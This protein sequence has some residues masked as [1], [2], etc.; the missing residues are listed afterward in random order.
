MM[1]GSGWGYP[2]LTC[3]AILL[4]LLIS[5]CAPTHGQA[6]DSI[7]A[8][9][10]SSVRGAQGAL[11]RQ[12]QD[13]TVTT[14]DFNEFNRGDYIGTQYEV[15]YGV[16]LSASGGLGFEPRIF[17]SNDIGTADYG[18][19]DLGSPNQRCP[20]GGPGV[21]EGG[22][23][24]QDGENC[25]AL[26]N[27]LIIQ[28]DNGV[29]SGI[30]DDNGG[31]GEIV[32][33]FTTQA[34]YVYEMG[35]LDTD[36]GGKITIEHE[37]GATTKILATW[38]DNAKEIKAIDIAKVNKITV[39][40]EKSGAV[41][42][43]SFCPGTDTEPS[44]TTPPPTTP[45]PTTP[46]PTTPSPTPLPGSPTSYTTTHVFSIDDVM[47]GFD[48]STFGP[49]GAMQDTTILCGLPSSTSPGTCPSSMTDKDGTVLYPIDSE[50]GFNVLDFVGAQ[51][52][53]RDFNHLEGF[54]GNVAGGGL[55][56]SNVGTS[57]YKTKPPLGTWCQGLSATS[58]KCSTEHYSV[59]EHVLSCHE[60]CPYQLA[61]PI[62]GEQ[63]VQS[64]PDGS[65]TFDCANAELDNDVKEITDGVVGDSY[66][67]PPFL[68]PNDNT[69]VLNEIA[70]SRDYSI[71]LKDDGK[72][73]YRW[74]SLI[75]LPTDVRLYAKLELPDEWKQTGADFTVKS[76]KLVVRHQI[77]NNPNDQ[78][79]PED[80]EN[81]AATGR[82]PS[83]A[84]S[85]SDGTDIWSSRVPCY[86]GD[87]DFIE[88]DDGSS[89][90]DFLPAGT[91]FKG[92]FKGDNLAALNPPQ[93]FSEDLVEG[94]TNGWYTTINRDPFEWS[95]RDTTQPDNIFDF[96]GFNEPLNDLEMATQNLELVSGPRWRLKA[97]KFGQDIPGTSGKTCLWST[98]VFLYANIF[99]SRT[100]QAST[101]LKKNAANHRSRWT[102]S[103]IA[104]GMKLS[105]P[106]T[107]SIGT[108]KR[109]GRLLWLRAR[110]GSTSPRT[111]SS[112]LTRS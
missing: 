49:S 56:I 39:E 19:P 34:E 27:L 53:S 91:V 7:Q 9:S 69:D 12:L 80:L 90:P 4:L 3:S 65:A 55:K 104:L 84:V 46:P 106:S 95:Y 110:A 43:I 61:D 92:K 86:E 35:F 63:A 15:Q 78:I 41:I 22:E 2:I 31:G 88:G 71:T 18:D 103:S 102:T 96:V 29:N 42:F 109:T 85:D 57:T 14:L 36:Y 5:A 50:F 1:H 45:P 20:Q 66:I 10:R 89:D 32:F 24:G 48:G 67:P 6:T 52:I 97:G 82:K 76:A 59:M 17:D 68:E 93:L 107:C 101:F 21:G 33:E 51:R 47:G 100:L 25:V 11:D 98:F 28:E 74:G 44:P 105:P 58:V 8:N 30:P 40:L 94:F 72:V 75:K 81:E 79:R 87:G 73:L 112:R 64:F 54:A 83:Y 77:T 62:T 99:I 60:V 108:R 26:D 37:D 38:G 23:P 111:D 70:T 13:C 16:K